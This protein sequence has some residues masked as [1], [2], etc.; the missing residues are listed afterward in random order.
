[1][2]CLTVGRCN[3][4]RVWNDANL[5]CAQDLLPLLQPDKPGVV[6]VL[7]LYGM[8][9]IGK[10]TLARELFSGLTKSSLRFSSRHFIEV[11]KD[12]PLLDKQREL[13]GLLAGSS[14]LTA[15]NATQLQQQLKQCT[16]H[17]GA[18]LLVLDDVWTEAQ[19]DA[20]LCIS[21]LSDGS[22]VILTG[23]SSHSL[24][25][26]D[27]SRTPLTQPNFDSLQTDSDSH[28]DPTER[29]GNSLHSVKDK[30]RCVA[31]PIE[32]LTPSEAE[33]LLCQHAFNTDQPPQQYAVAVQQALAVC[34][35]LPIALQVVG[36][37]LRNHSPAEAEVGPLLLAAAAAHVAPCTMLA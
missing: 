20:L 11:G 10:T 19:R 33:Q 18:L 2:I 13:I 21:A 12:T 15:R 7:S 32:A 9:G 31:R 35:G 34:G 28:A 29:T 36:A 37:G 17:A 22:R 1:M 3:D 4:P 30:P 16:Q 27:S 8:G 6:L 5:P 24:H 23:R 25:P 14:S 26:D